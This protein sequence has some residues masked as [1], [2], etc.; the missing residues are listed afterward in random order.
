MSAINLAV[1][2][3][4]TDEGFRAVAYQDTTGHLTIGYGFNITSG[5]SEYAAQALLEAQAQELA[6]SLQAYHWFVGLDD[7]RASVLIELAFNLGL[8][9]LLH[10]PRM[11]GAIGSGDWQTAHDQLLDSDAARQLTSR[12]TILANLLLTGVSP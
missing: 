3:L 1:E 10:F 6:T 9:G 2:R 7:V 4:Q 5:I 8:N 12:Y 11:L